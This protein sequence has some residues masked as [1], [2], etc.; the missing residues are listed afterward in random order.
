MSSK[1]F[2]D[3]YN[4]MIGYVIISN[5]FIVSMINMSMVI[6]ILPIVGLPLPLVSYGGSSMISYCIGFGIILSID[7]SRRN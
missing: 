4:K 6:G 1:S 2:S 5:Y 3:N 7:R